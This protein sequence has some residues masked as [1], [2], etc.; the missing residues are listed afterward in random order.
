MASRD[1]SDYSDRR[2]PSMII[3]TPAPPQVVAGAPSLAFTRGWSAQDPRQL[4]TLE[5]GFGGRFIRA[6]FFGDHARGTTEGTGFYAIVPTS[7]L[8]SGRHQLQVRLTFVDG[9][10]S[11]ITGEATLV[12]DRPG[13][14]EVQPAVPS[15]NA[16]LVAICMTTHEPDATRFERQIESIRAQSHQ[17]FVV[18]L[19]DDASSARGWSLV[20]DVVGADPRFVITRSSVRR[21]FY[22]NFE[23]A[24]GLVPREADF[25]AFADQDDVWH[26]EKLSVL[27]TSLVDRG[28]QL[29]YCD[30]NIVSAAGELLAPTYW[31]SRRNNYEDL[32][33]L[34]LMNTVTGAASVFRRELID[35]ALPFPPDVGGAY[36]DQWLACVALSLGKIAYT[37]RPLQDYVQHDR[38]VVGRYIPSGDFE[39]GLL[40]AFG[41]LAVNPRV[42]I[43]NTT[44]NARRF[45]FED[46][47]RVEL[48][49]RTLQMRIG[50]ETRP[51]KA[52]VI[53]RFSRLS[54]S[55]SSLA[56][57]ALRSARDLRGG[58]ASLGAE[59]QMLKGLLW[60]N[61]T[62]L[63]AYRP[64]GWVTPC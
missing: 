47:I 24:L 38:N 22:R 14:P 30:M 53:D 2:L 60:K 1:P 40:H 29:A 20:G 8:E 31:S 37:D 59:N 3:E 57:L 48:M 15:G 56:W 42:R 62:A 52:A 17:R 43:R 10:T 49:A 4:R 46:V 61:L 51:D 12:V 7:N 23:R 41:R 27:V 21:G 28:A 36:H 39:S 34:L 54:T 58:A 26:P 6:A 35:V 64:R 13:A 50:R 11:V 18:L 44:R 9:S 25:V 5:I 16:P 55:R 32:A 33:T 19:S 63:R 45:F